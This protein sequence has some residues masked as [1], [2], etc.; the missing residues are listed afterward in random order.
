M[1]RLRAARFLTR[2]ASNLGS[3][4][5]KAFYASIGVLEAHPTSYF[6]YRSII[7]LQGIT[8]PQSK[9]ILGSGAKIKR[10]V[11]IIPQNGRI[12]LGQNCSIN[13]FC[14]LYG[15]GDITIGNDV[16]MASGCKIIAFNHES[17][18]ISVPIIRQGSK[19]LG[20]TI[21]N[22]VWLGADVKVVDGVTVGEGSIIGAGAVVVSDVEPFTIV[23]GVP[24]RKIR[25]RS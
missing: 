1:I 7:S 20:I 11:M 12:S 3:I 5:K 24:A 23:G 14:V 18:D 15:Y 21:E 8:S 22:N 13:P 9:L 16:R 2:H 6:S 10:Y 17:D 19:M 25:T 4:L